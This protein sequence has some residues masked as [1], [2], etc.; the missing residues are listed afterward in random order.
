M[1][2][3]IFDK[4][5]SYQEFSTFDRRKAKR[6][7]FLHPKITLQKEKQWENRECR[8]RGEEK[9]KKAMVALSF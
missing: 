7:S 6:E 2:S 5:R 8:E 3:W 9:R 4:V 1:S